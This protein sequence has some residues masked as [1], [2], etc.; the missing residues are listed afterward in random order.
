MSYSELPKYNGWTNYPTW[1]TA[2][3]MDND[4]DSYLYYREQAR[5]AKDTWELSKSLKAEY[6]DF[7]NIGVDVTGVFS[8]LMT[9]AL[10]YVNW[11]EIA[12]H[13]LDES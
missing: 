4:E 9:W 7:D 5:R 13:L 11:D 8:D 6:N 12:E 10:A 1:V 3:W 2:L